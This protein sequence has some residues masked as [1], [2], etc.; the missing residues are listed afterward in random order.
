MDTFNKYVFTNYGVQM[1]DALTI[2]RLA[3]NIFLD[4]YL[5]ESK[6]PVISQNMYNDIKKAYYGGLTEVY[7][8]YGKNLYYY[9]VNSLYPY[10]ALNSMPGIHCTYLESLDNSYLDLKELFGF[11]YCEI[12]TKDSYLGLLPVHT[13][14]ELIMPNGKWEG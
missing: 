9:D 2:S 12:E 8:P 3:L 11:F 1:T 14:F 5:K 6:I 13:N 4:K 7:K 10:V